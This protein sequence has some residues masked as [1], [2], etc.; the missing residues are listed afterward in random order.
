LFE[1]RENVLVAFPA[2]LV[3]IAAMFEL[4]GADLSPLAAPNYTPVIP[5]PARLPGT[6]ITRRWKNGMIVSFI[7][8]LTL[9]LFYLFVRYPPRIRV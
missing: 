5:E 6:V 9:L 3:S 8:V 2:S 7:L 1:Q 4:S